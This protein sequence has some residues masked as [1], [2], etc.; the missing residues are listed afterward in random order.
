VKRELLGIQ[1]LIG[2]DA[3]HPMEVYETYTISID[4]RGKRGPSDR[5]WE[6]P[7]F[8]DPKEDYMSSLEVKKA[9]LDMFRRIYIVTNRL[10]T[11]P[12]MYATA[13]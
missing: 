2:R 6:K 10:T 11:L 7:D 12:G 1:F 9:I 5:H 8:H 4:Y 3:D 13:V